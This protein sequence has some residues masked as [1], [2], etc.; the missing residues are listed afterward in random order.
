MIRERIRQLESKTLSL[1]PLRGTVSSDT[2]GG[3]APLFALLQIVGFVMVGPW[4][5]MLVGRGLARI[6]RRVPG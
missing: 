5:C 2:L 3:L 6:S 4:L 1:D